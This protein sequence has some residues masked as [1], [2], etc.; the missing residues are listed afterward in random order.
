MTRQRHLKHRF[1]GEDPYMG[2]L[3]RV[4]VIKIDQPLVTLGCGYRVCTIWETVC[5]VVWN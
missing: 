4:F 1:H 5:A 3:V 2:L